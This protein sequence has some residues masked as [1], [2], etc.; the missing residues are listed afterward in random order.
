MTTTPRIDPEFRALIPDPSPEERQQLTDNLLRDGCRDP[1]VVWQGTLL[2][3]YTRLPICTEHNIPYQT[4]EQDCAD[5][6][7]AK[8]W[9]IRNQLGRRNLHPYQRGELA[10]LL[11]PLAAA[12]AKARQA[13]GQTAPGKAG[14]LYQNSGKA[15][16]ADVITG[17]TAG[18]S[19][20]TMHRIKA[21]Q[22]H[23]PEEV[24][25][26]LRL[27]K[28]KIHRA[29]QQL[30]RT[31]LDRKPKTKTKKKATAPPLAGPT[32][33]VRARAE[34][35]AYAEQVE[36]ETLTRD[37]LAKRWKKDP[38]NAIKILKGVAALWDV[39]EDDGG[40]PG[41]R[42][43]RYTVV[44]SS[45]DVKHFTD[46]WAEYKRVMLAKVREERKEARDGYHKWRP[47]NVKTVNMSALLD[48]L[49]DELSK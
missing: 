45:S 44:R 5:R 30:D 34:L 24:K 22:R 18:L 14:T 37:E 32:F 42:Y 49:E 16:H 3:G 41:G 26:A 8:A 1:L 10:L 19:K 4:V 23:A 20:D 11:E 31:Q 47:D 40:R 29:Y 38:D 2:D 7:A 6:D 17:R 43:S 33:A 46:L 39:I 12:E 28:M 36:G 27:G 21:I 35:T 25:E 9:I 13:H 15:I 48:W